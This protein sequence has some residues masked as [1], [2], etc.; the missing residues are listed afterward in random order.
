[1]RDP[2]ACRSSGII[3]VLCLLLAAVVL[4]AYSNHFGNGF[5]FDDFT[6]VTSNPA[7][8]SLGAT[9]RFFV[10]PTLFSVAPG[11]RTYRPI[12]SASLAL[13][14]WLGGG[15]NVF[16][17]HLSSFLWYCVQLGLLFL[18]FR[19]I[20]DLADPH[21]TNLWTALAAA[22]VYGLHP[23]NAETVN[24]VIQRA[25][26][27][28]TLG[29]VASL[30]LFLRYPA[31]R[32][33]GW[34]LL[35]AAA[36]MLA[37]PPALIF[38]LLL[39]AYVLLFELDGAAGQGRKWGGVLRSLLPAVA[40]AGAAAW[41]LHHMQAPTWTNGAASPSLYRLTQ[42]WVALH[43]FRMFFWPDELAIDAGW[44]SVAGPFAAP[45]LA[46][47][48]FALVLLVVAAAAA[49]K[50]VARPVAFGIFWFLAALLPT[51]L[52]PLGDLTNDHRMFFPFVGLTLAVCWAVRMALFL[53]AA[54][55]AGQRRWVYASAA[56][57][58]AVVLV[59]EGAGTHSRNRVWATEEA[60][61]RDAT[62]KYP[63]DAKAWNNYGSFFFRE[64]DYDAAL[65]CWKRAAALDPACPLY[66]SNLV[67]ISLNLHDG[68]EAER[69]FGRLLELNPQ[70]PEPYIAYADWLRSKG[71][72]AESGKLL[73]RAAR[74]YPHSPELQHA[75]LAY[76]QARDAADRIPVHSA[77]DSDRDLSL[78]AEEI[79]AAPAALLSLD[80]NG[81]GK[82][83]A[84]ELGADFG[85]ES[86]LDAASLQ[87]LRRAFM[88][89][90]PL[91]YAL[92]RNHDGE[93][94]AS[95]IRNAGQALRTLDRDGDG[96]VERYEV[97]PHCVVAAARSVLM[98]LDRDRDGTI[99]TAERSSPEGEL[100]REL[101]DAA[102]VDGDGIVTLEELTNEIFYRADRNKDGT[103][104]G[105]ELREAI[106]AGLLGPIPVH[107]MHSVPPSD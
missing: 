107:A 106:R 38:P 55:R 27:Y 35:P 40:V 71:R 24:Y 88:R 22:A 5:H 100:F 90:H 13:D 44:H 59:A 68:Q 32:R 60:L 10:D 58:L 12:T 36:A 16:W 25:D 49:R 77:L 64:G 37:K 47:Y 66:Q 97:A 2:C 50:R 15:L 91:L 99:D 51:S 45:A 31:Q 79:L 14:Y 3:A 103:V 81:D 56:A 9:P 96:V 43:Y 61:W 34:Y 28:N 62:L 76:F 95:E 19:R 74:L 29:C 86:R 83:S 82:L 46:G 41:L 23:A 65:P 54:G 26:L 78:S 72:F 11:Q 53:L 69:H 7:I 17:F 93:I 84:E 1:M 94:S 30:W 98:A 8:R 20:M 85:D 75:R 80:K 57:A 4:A 87:R 102:D 73:D 70:I 105:E 21:P 92:D 18:L 104:T 6:A 52:M 63:L 48:A 101:L 33:F 89:A 39:A 42:P 67:R